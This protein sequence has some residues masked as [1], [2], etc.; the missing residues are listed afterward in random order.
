MLSS[1]SRTACSFGS[2]PSGVVDGR[3]CIYGGIPIGA[4]NLVGVVC[5]AFKRLLRRNIRRFHVVVVA[6][7]W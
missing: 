3:R 7:C 2:I 1:V 5:L 6:L 4:C